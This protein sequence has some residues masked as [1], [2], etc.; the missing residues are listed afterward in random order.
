MEFGQKVGALI[1]MAIPSTV[2][3]IY[4]YDLLHSWLVVIVWLALMPFLYWAIITGKFK[5]S[6]TAS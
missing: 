5:R 2:G 1:L 6:R 3:S 4:F